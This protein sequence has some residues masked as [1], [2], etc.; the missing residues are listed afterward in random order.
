[1]YDTYLLTYLLTYL[2]TWRR[3]HS[4]W[5]SNWQMLFGTDKIKII[6]VDFNKNEAS[7]VLR[8]SN[9]RLMRKEIIGVIDKTLEP[10]KQCAR[11][12]AACA[13]NAVV[14]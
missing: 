8:P 14:S 10:R 13:A 5:S 7:Y 1:M 11:T 4:K 6:D 12:K 3:H 2:D 9:V